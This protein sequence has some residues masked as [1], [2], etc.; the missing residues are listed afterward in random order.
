MNLCACLGPVDGDPYCPCEMK[1]RGLTSN[2]KPATASIAQAL[3]FKRPESPCI[4]VCTT[5]YDEKCK[6]C[7]RTYMEVAQWNAMSDAEKEVVW[8]RIDAEA[9]AW[10]FNKYKDRA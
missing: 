2:R 10:R 3:G 5:L 7:G 9:S 6:G 8:V 4:A 1:H